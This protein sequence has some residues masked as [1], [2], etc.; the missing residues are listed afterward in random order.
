MAIAGGLILETAL[1]TLSYWFGSFTSKWVGELRW[2]IAGVF[3]L[4][5]FFIARHNI[6]A[7]RATKNELNAVTDTH[8]PL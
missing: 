6:L 3:L 7:Y 8:T 1:F 4:I 5:L 2:G